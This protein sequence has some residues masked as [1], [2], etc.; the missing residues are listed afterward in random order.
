MGKHVSE[1]FRKAN[2]AAFKKGM[3]LGR[4]ALGGA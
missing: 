1:R 3:D 2:L 4:Q